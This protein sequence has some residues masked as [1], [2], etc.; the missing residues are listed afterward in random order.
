[1]YYC[2]KFKHKDYHLFNKDDLNFWNFKKKRFN[3][4]KELIGFFK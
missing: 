3:S 4:N 2:I 1:M